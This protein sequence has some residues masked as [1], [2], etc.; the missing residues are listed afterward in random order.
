MAS[1]HAADPVIFGNKVRMEPRDEDILLEN[2]L[3]L[4]QSVEKNRT[5]C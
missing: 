5:E 1:L 4:G 2:P 3:I